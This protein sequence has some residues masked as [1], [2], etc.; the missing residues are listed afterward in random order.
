MTRTCKREK[1][2]KRHEKKFLEGSLTQVSLRQLPFD[3]QNTYV[4]RELEK[5]FGTSNLGKMNC[6]HCCEAALFDN[7]AITD[8]ELYT[9]SMSLKIEKK[10]K[11]MRHF[12]V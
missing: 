4:R 10:K 9:L 11:D 8:E 7:G 6:S 3:K 1:A 5:K 2:F 12:N